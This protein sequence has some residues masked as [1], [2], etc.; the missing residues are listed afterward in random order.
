MFSIYDPPSAINSSGERQCCAG[1]GEES[2][3]I[4]KCGSQCGCNAGFCAECLAQARA[5]GG[6][7]CPHCLGSNDSYEMCQFSQS[8]RT[9]LLESRPDGTERV[10]PQVLQVFQD[11]MNTNARK[12][13]GAADYISYDRKTPLPRNMNVIAVYELDNPN[14]GKLYNEK[15]KNMRNREGTG[16]HRLPVDNFQPGSVPAWMN[17]MA[18]GFPADLVLTEQILMG[19]RKA[20]LTRAVPELDTPLGPN[21]YWFWHGTSFEVRS[22]GV[23][24]SRDGELRTRWFDLNVAD[25]NYHYTGEAEANRQFHHIQKD[26]LPS[27]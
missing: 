14:D 7:R 12:R 25:C 4:L 13:P 1:C 22:C 24:C 10:N 18:G 9:L 15:L 20:G 26:Q 27:R 3:A 5:K 8:S 16:L 6:K 19:L 2:A 17:S 23:V 11:L 21:E